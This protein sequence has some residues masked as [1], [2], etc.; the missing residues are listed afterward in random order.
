MAIQWALAAYAYM[1]AGNIYGHLL[2]TIRYSCESA[3]IH[4]GLLCV[5]CITARDTYDG[6]ILQFKLPDCFDETSK[7][8]F[9]GRYNFRRVCGIRRTRYEQHDTAC[10]D[11]LIYRICIRLSNDF[12]TCW[13]H[14]NIVM[15]RLI[16]VTGTCTHCTGKGRV[17][18]YVWKFLQLTPLWR[19]SLLVITDAMQLNPSF[20]LWFFNS[21]ISTELGVVNSQTKIQL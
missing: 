15:L 4:S 18:I 9:R 14:C 17:R 2:W 10:I 1:H 7:K 16:C 6:Y 12:C 3:D 13:P 20:I 19:A 21:Q 11:S 5:L 8:L